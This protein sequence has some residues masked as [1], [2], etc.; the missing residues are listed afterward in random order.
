MLTLDLE[1]F[2]TVLKMH[3]WGRRL[4]KKFSYYKLFTDCLTKY[5]C[6][7]RFRPGLWSVDWCTSLYL[8]I[9]M[10]DRLRV[11]SKKK[12]SSRVFR[13][14]RTLRTQCITTRKWYWYYAKK[15]ISFEN[16]I[17]VVS[18]SFFFH[19]DGINI[20]EHPNHNSSSLFYIA[21]YSHEINI[22]LILFSAVCCY[23]HI[24][25]T[26]YP[27]LYELLFRHITVHSFNGTTKYLI[28]LERN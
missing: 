16:I 25:N 28:C 9:H 6:V 19:L 26:L 22:I 27:A 20:V 4:C 15:K 11:A 24:T 17:V 21:I 5:K 7:T 8:S 3:F 1:E 10:K 13:A 23:V 2:L 14:T 18:F 12:M